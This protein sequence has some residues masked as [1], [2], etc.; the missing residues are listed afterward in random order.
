MGPRAL[1]SRHF[2]GPRVALFILRLRCVDGARNVHV[3]AA[4]GHC[5]DVDAST[6]EAK[7][8]Y[9]FRHNEDRPGMTES[10]AADRS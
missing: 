4:E 8:V 2:R 7:D 5:V 6:S 10:G 1:L 3:A 9:A